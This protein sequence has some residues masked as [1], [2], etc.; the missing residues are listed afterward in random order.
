MTEYSSHIRVMKSL[1]EET[2]R[3]R[4]G[5]D[6]LY[7]DEVEFAADIDSL[8]DHVEKLESENGRATRLLR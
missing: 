4:D 8:L 1:R 3:I 5:D 6:S 2:Q 7:P